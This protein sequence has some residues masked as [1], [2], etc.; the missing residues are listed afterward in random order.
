MLTAIAGAC[1][2]AV[3]HWRSN[4]AALEKALKEEETNKQKGEERLRKLDEAF[5]ACSSLG[6]F[7]F[8]RDFEFGVKYD[9]GSC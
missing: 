2:A 9:C 8:G 5:L 4:K 7:S 6:V 3:V 1:C